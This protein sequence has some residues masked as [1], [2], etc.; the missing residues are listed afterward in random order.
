MRRLASLLSK[1]K[2]NH[3]PNWLLIC[4][5][6]LNIQQ[7]DKGEGTDSSLY[8]GWMD[9]TYETMKASSPLEVWSFVLWGS[10]EASPRNVPMVWIGL[11][12]TVTGG[13]ALP[14]AKWLSDR[15]RYLYSCLYARPNRSLC[16]GRAFRVQ[17]S[18]PYFAVVSTV[19]RTSK[20]AALYTSKYDIQSAE[21]RM[22][23]VTADRERAC[24]HEEHG[25][26]SPLINHLDHRL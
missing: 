8:K 11:V 17:E 20:E 15:P 19:Q 14:F 25:A 9:T 21:H 24:I 10:G 18:R 2:Q 12:V 16:S 23:A 26:S 1:F 13:C 4:W 3:A 22:Q 7:R 5:L 6:V